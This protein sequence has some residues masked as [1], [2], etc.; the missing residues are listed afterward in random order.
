MGFKTTL[1]IT[2]ILVC[3]GHIRVVQAI[4]DENIDDT[5]VASDHRFGG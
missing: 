5:L 4:Q 3:F 1:S 2:L